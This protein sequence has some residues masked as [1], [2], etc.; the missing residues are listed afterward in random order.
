VA[1]TPGARIVARLTPQFAYLPGEVRLAFS[2]DDKRLAIS[3]SRDFYLWNL[4]DQSPVPSR[5]PASPVDELTTSPDGMLVV[6]LTR[7]GPNPAGPGSAAT[8]SAAT[9]KQIS[10]INFN[11]YAFPL[12]SSA[13]TLALV[14]ALDSS[15]SLWDART[16]AHIRDLPYI[17]GASLYYVSPVL[18]SPDGKIL[19]LEESNYTIYLKDTSTG[20]VLSTMQSGHDIHQFLVFSADSKTLFVNLGTR[21]SVWS[22]TRHAVIKTLT[23]PFLG[24]SADGRLF[25]STAGNAVN[26][27]NLS[28]GKV[29][30]TLPDP[31]GSRPATAS[32][33]PDG[34]EIALA[35]QNDKIYVWKLP[36]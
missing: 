32:F 19:V 24:A 25:A 27:I 23:V 13:G 16:G 29:V 8:W 11:G 2:S 7:Q 28:T 34:K 18:I 12:V 17:G 36:G 21:T 9:G 33:S 3:D 10:T 31:A 15:I 30:D 1:T 5:L 26:I 6:Y 4:A 35:D 22:A 14:D 20:A